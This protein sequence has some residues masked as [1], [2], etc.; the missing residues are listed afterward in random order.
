MTLTKSLRPLAR[1]E[2]F[3]DRPAH[4]IPAAASN[5]TVSKAATTSAPIPR[6]KPMLL[7]IFG[8]A[9]DPSALIRLP[10]GKIAEVSRGDRLGPDTVLAVAEDSVILKRGNKAQRL[11]MPGA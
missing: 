9:D 11:T 1:P 5:S 8:S 3:S 4:V 2:G 6:A 10:S 7:G